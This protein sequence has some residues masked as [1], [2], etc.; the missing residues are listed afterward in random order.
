MKST[1]PATP[2]ERPHFSKSFYLGKSYFNSDELIGSLN[3]YFDFTKTKFDWDRGGIGKQS[4]RWYQ[5][6]GIVARQQKIRKRRPEEA[7]QSRV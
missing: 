7:G 6:P 1:C 2:G 5:R 4:E 3:S